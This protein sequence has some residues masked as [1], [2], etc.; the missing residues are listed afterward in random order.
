MPDFTGVHHL[1]LT[2]SDLDRAERWYCD[3]LGLQKLVDMP[4]SDEHRISLLIHP[5][6]QLL[7]GL[8]W[9]A[10]NDGSAFSETRCGLDHA[11]FGVA[12]RG[13]LEE[14]KARLDELGVDNSGITDAPYGFVLVFRDPDNIQLELF[15]MPPG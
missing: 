7:V 13:A 2:V 11:S 15:S 9:H 5:G 1:A 4:E 3:V 10:G 8:H 6:S 12:D 14:W